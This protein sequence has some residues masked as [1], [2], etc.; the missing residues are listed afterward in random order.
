MDFVNP[1]GNLHK[2]TKFG[3]WGGAP[4]HFYGTWE[5]PTGRISP[6]EVKRNDFQMEQL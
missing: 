2:V 3:G 4:L 6:S 5:S 1:L